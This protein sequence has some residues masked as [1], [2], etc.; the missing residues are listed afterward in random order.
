[1][2][3]R[4]KSVDSQLVREKRNAARRKGVD[5]LLSNISLCIHINTTS[6]VLSMSY[7]LSLIILLV[8]I[9]LIL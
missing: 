5:R 8:D 4:N 7:S 6:P 3:A 2:K 9:K 1:M